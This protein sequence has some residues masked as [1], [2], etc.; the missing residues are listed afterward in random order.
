MKL[1]NEVVV[2]RGSVQTFPGPD[3]LQEVEIPISRDFRCR[4]YRRLTCGLRDE[5]P[6]LERPC[7][8]DA[9][10]VPSL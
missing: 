3:A 1:L 5:L 4:A 10:A 6:L 2:E 7:V 8:D 9:S